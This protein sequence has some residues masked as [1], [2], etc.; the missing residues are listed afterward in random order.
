MRCIECIQK[1]T[2]NENAMGALTPPN[3][4]ELETDVL[5]DFS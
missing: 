1:Q 3:I 2:V 5:P 4:G